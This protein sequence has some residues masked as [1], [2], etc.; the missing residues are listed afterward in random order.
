MGEKFDNPIL[1]FLA[2]KIGD[3][4]LTD[5]ERSRLKKVMKSFNFEVKS[6]NKMMN[7]LA[8]PIKK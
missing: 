3:D 4:G 2:T 7:M 5:E 6:K 1:N 8:A